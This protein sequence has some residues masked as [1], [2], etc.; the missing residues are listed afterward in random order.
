MTLLQAKDDYSQ[1]YIEALTERTPIDVINEGGLDYTPG[2]PLRAV[3]EGIATVAALSQDTTEAEC[4]K[5][6]REVMFLLAGVETIPASKASGYLTITSTQTTTLPAGSPVYSTVTGSKVAETVEEVV[7]TDVEII[8]VNILADE[9]G[10]E[11]SFPA[12]TLFLTAEFLSGTNPL[13]INNGKD[14]ETDYARTQRVQPALKAKSQGTLQAL[15]NV[16]EAVVLTNESGIVTESVVSALL[17]FPWKHEDP[18]TLD[19]TRIGE[20][21]MSVQSSDG[22]PSQEILDAIELALVGTDELDPS[23]KQGAG[24]EVVVNPVDTE[25]IAFSVPYFIAVGGVEAQIETDVQSAVTTYV[26]SLTQGQSINPTDWQAAIV[27][28]EGVDHYDE[29]NLSPSTLQT[30]DVNEI[31]N[32]TSIT[33]TDV[34]P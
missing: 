19:P 6:A 22:V 12:T 17:S 25:D 2:G 4:K 30:L 3:G 5:Q 34:T 11:V 31:W 10:S 27:G 13:L 32:I 14:A 20:I 33:V 7:F 1:K 8:D 29:P 23:G 15:I 18:E 9:A 26:N 28:V 21:V 24:Q 16:A